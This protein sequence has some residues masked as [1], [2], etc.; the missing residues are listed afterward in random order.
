M[1]F[2]PVLVAVAAVAVHAQEYKPGPVQSLGLTVT[3]LASGGATRSGAGYTADGHSPNYSRPTENYTQERTRKSQTRLGVNITNLGR[4]EATAKVEWIFFGGDV[5]GGGQFILNREDRM[6]T[7]AP[8]KT[9]RFEI[10]SSEAS[11]RTER[12]LSVS[13]VDTGS[14]ILRDSSAAQSRD[15]IT[16]KGWL[17][18]LIAN[19]KV[20]AARASAPSYEA[21]ARNDTALLSFPTEAP[22]V[23][24][25]FP[26][27]I[28][29]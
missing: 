29:R 1:R 13:T 17:V 18:R 10:E 8:A 14:Q 9:E 11:S 24:S 4:A 16:L 15:G 6:V 27:A 19:E 23:P 26:P 12:R 22:V 5:K 2:I 7:V 25:R 28:P 21:L 3:P 20:Y